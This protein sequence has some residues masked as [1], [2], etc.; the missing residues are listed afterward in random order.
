MARKTHE[1]ALGVAGSETVIGTG[2]VVRGNLVSESDITCDGTLT[3]KI[4]TAG[5]VTIGMNGRITADIEAANVSVAGA[6]TGNILA[7]GIATIRETGHVEG[8]IRAQSLSISSGAVFI[9]RSI[10]EGAPQLEH[11]PSDQLGPGTD[12]GSP[13]G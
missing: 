3:G 10:M 2:V 5:D 13:T 7:A 8:D 12:P 9:G 6:V 1:D 11:E 4:K